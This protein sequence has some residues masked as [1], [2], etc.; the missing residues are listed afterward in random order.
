M[1]EHE[2]QKALFE[3][4]AIMANQ[5]PAWNMLVAIP[6]GQ[7]RPGQRKEPGLKRGFPDMG[8]FVPRGGYHGLFVE[9]KYGRN[10]QTDAQKQWEY[11]LT[12]YGYLSMT[13]WGFE[14]AKIGIEEYLDMEDERC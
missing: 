2:D 1:T 9:L 8:L 3:Y 10:K 12:E 7:Y 6:N 13:C 5:D 14:W 4:A 11:K